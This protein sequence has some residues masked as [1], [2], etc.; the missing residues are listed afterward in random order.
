PITVLNP[1]LHKIIG[2]K[3]HQL[4]GGRLRLAASGGAALPETVAKTFIGLGVNIFQ[5]YGMTESS[6]AVTMNCFSL[7]VPQSVGEKMPGVELRIGDNDELQI[8]GPMVMLGYWNNHQAT[9]EILTEDGWLRTGDKARIDGR[10]VYITGRIKDILIMSNGEKVPPVDMEQAITLE[11]EFEQALIIGEGKSYLSALVVLN[12]ET[13][14]QIAQE[15]GIDPLD[16]ESLKNKKLMSAMLKVIA[17]ALHDFPGY[18]KVRR[19][20][21]SLQPW[22]IEDGFITPTLKIKRAIII[23]HFQTEID[24]MYK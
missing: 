9:S 2:T 16:P 24:A 7:N 6:P 15:H 5:G 22:T 11:P 4:L 8:K 23:E 20:S 17:K 18:A 13:W 12:G 3:I 21:L 19:I 1:L 10:S 14:P